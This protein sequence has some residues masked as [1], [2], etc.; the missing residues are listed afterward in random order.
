MALKNF[1]VKL[2]KSIS[3]KYKILENFLSIGKNILFFEFSKS[4]LKIIEILFQNQLKF[5]KADKLFLCSHLVILKSG[6]GLIISQSLVFR[7]QKLNLK[8]KQN[9]SG[10]FK[11]YYTDINTTVFNNYFK[12]FFLPF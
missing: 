1:W 3:L 7:V 9:L 8:I 11:K 4:T 2:L 10:I 12:I 5:K 6:T